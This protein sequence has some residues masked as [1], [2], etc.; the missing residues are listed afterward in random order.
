MN[1]IKAEYGFEIKEESDGFRITYSKAKYGFGAM[2]T[3]LIFGIMLGIA[4]SLMFNQSDDMLPLIWFVAFVGPFAFPL[5]L[6]SRRTPEEFV[7]TNEALIVGGSKYNRDDIS[8]IFVKDK[9]SDVQLSVSNTGGGVFVGGTGAAGAVTAT[10]FAA[11]QAMQA[12]GHAAGAAAAG[13]AAKVNVKIMFTYGEKYLA[14]A[15]GLNRQRAEVLFSKILELL[16]KT[17]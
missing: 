10:A 1:K 15:K 14:L 12:S 3:F 8:N 2:F 16:E 7:I 4:L 9:S 13:V 6:N 11:G 17:N 5:F